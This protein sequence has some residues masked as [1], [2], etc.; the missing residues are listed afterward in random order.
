MLKSKTKYTWEGW[1]SSGREDWVFS[2]KHPCELI[3]VHA[4]LIDVQLKESEKV[5]YCVY[6]PRLSSTLTPFG[7]RSEEAS[8]GICV[9]DKRFIISENRH[10]KGIEP[11][12]T[13]I[14]FE[15]IQY[16]NIGNALILGWFSIHYCVDGNLK[17]I[18]ILFSSTGRHHFE[19]LIRTYKKYSGEDLMDERGIETYYP[20]SFIYNI[21]DN[22]HRND[23][24]TLISSSEKCVST[25][26][27]QYIWGVV[28]RKRWPWGRRDTIYVK[29][30]A[31]FLLTSKGLLI[32]RNGVEA[33]GGVAVD[34]LSISIDKI[35]KV[36][37]ANEKY[38]ESEIYNLEII[39][40][41]VSAVAN[42][43]LSIIVHG[44]DAEALLKRSLSVIADT[45]ERGQYDEV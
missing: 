38:M 32:A 43:P 42:L 28:K 14:D 8:R 44:R 4:K 24:K 9:T 36:I 31:T 30:N 27:C 41:N 1:E 10:V 3:G 2:V 6:S 16:F 22:I 35:K 40:S 13:S 25:F 5:E 15:D 29:N 17:D 23:L 7:L 11:S 26:S 12:L 33:A 39:F 20:S 34:I 19:K 18:T 21:K 45:K 37:V